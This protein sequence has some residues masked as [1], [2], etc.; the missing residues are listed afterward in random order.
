MIQINYVFSVR[1]AS[2]LL[3]VCLVVFK[4]VHAGRGL[5]F[6][7]AKVMFFTVYKSTESSYIR[8]PPIPCY[9]SWYLSVEVK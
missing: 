4:P 2:P 3:S 8:L 1:A 5:L 7:K 6:W 9:E